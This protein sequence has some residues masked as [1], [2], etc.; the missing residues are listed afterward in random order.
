MRCRFAFAAAFLSLAGALA[1]SL[2]LSQDDPERELERIQR[3]IAALERDLA[4]QIGRRDDGMAELRRI[5]LALADTQAELGSLTASVAAQTARQAEIE[6]ERRAANE[7]LDG[8]QAALAEQI[9]L[10]YMTGRQEMLKLLLSQD[11]EADTGRMLVYYDYLN[12]HR[13]Q[14]IAAVDAELEQLAALARENEAVGRELDRLRA[15]QEARAAELASEESERRALLASLDAEIDSSGSRIERM[16]AEEAELEDTIA[17]LAEILEGFAVNSD[18]P[19]A[20][21]RG[22]LPWPVEGPLAARF[23]DRRDA[24]GLI[25]WDG[26]LI[27]APEGTPVRAVYQ[28]RVI[29]AQWHTHMG[30][31]LIVDHGDGYWSLYGHNRALLR[32]TDDWVRAGDVIAEVGSTG[33]RVESALYFSLLKDQTPIDPAAWAP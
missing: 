22:Q 18:A 33:G 24:E 13:G 3:E 14:R 27:E 23:G 29:H 6:A 20:T 5:E 21:Q 1:P 17:R 11:S 2:S 8:E 9:R 32:S 4:R 16:R 26:V 7:R 30:L 12:R 10:S 19:F 15:E 28:G 31:L 25:R